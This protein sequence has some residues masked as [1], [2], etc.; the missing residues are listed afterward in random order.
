[1]KKLLLNTLVGLAVVGFVVALC[2]YTGNI[3]EGELFKPTSH[4]SKVDSFICN[5]RDG[6]MTWAIITCVI[7]LSA[8][9]GTGIR[10]LFT[11]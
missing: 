10:N 7:M 4:L 3:L 6:T 2:Y 8:M 1:M 5:L 11:R 9:I